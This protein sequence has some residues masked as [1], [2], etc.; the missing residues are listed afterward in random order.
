MDMKNSKDKAL[1]ILLSVI[2]IFVVLSVFSGIWDSEQKIKHIEIHGAIIVPE[3]LIMY[4]VS[5]KIK[6]KFKKNINLNKIES[7]VKQSK[8]IQ[9]VSINFEGS[10]KI[11]INI[12]ERKPVACVADSYGNLHFFDKFGIVM[13]FTNAYKPEKLF[14][15]NDVLFNKS[16]KSVLSEIA[17]LIEELKKDKYKY[18]LSDISDIKYDYNSNSLVIKS[19]FGYDLIIGDKYNLN[20][21]LTKLDYFL[22]NFTYEAKNLEYIDCRW[23]RMMVMKN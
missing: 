15:V 17:L 20:E 9:N 2:L 18:I 21:K 11:I 7:S 23:G 8:Y 6:D 4:S 5:S 1:L 19:K 16:S 10:N 3:N 14:V 22:Q 12:T 13:P